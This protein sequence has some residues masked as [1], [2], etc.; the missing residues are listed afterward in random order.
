MSF[1]V[2]PTSVASSLADAHAWS[3][4]AAPSAAAPT[5]GAV[6]VGPDPLSSERPHEAAASRR[7]TAMTDAERRMGTATPRWS[8]ESYDEYSSSDDEYFDRLAMCPRP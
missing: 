6:V 5:A 7:T 8:D 3:M 2:T 1:A 4:S